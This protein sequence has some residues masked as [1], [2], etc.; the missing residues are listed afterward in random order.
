MDGLVGMV[1]GG[2]IKEDLG[3][4]DLQSQTRP[5]QGSRR[6]CILVAYQKVSDIWLGLSFWDLV[7]RTQL[8]RVHQQQGLACFG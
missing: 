1:L 2:C 6:M 3:G 4:Y 7:N 5:L 8:D